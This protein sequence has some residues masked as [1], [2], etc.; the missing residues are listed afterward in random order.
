MSEIRVVSIDGLRRRLAVALADDVLLRQRFDR[1][2]SDQDEKLIESAMDSLR[3]YPTAVR[4]R[5]EEV[6][7]TWLF[8]GPEDLADLPVIGRSRH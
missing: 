1:A 5:V 6:L 2:L 8:D 4:E 7:L 3:L